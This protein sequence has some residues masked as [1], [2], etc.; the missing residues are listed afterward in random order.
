MKRRSELELSLAL[1]LRTDSTFH[2][3][4]LLHEMRPAVNSGLTPEFWA[5]FATIQLLT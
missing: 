3:H 2:I 1:L 5:P 4:Q